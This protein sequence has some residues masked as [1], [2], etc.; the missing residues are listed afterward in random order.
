MPHTEEQVQELVREMYS[1]AESN[2]WD[3]DAVEIRSQRKGRS[4]PLP[5]VKVLV[6]V[7]AAVILIVVGI[8]VANGSPSHRSTASGPTTTASATLV[9]VPNATN[10][11]LSKATSILHLAGLTAT[12]TNIVNNTVAG[13]VLSQNPAAGL[14]VRRGSAVALIVSRGPS[15]VRVPSLVGL[16]QSQATNVLGQAG[17]NVGNISSAP[18]SNFAA[19]FVIE[20]SPAAGASAPPGSSV[21]VVVSSGPRG[22]SG[23]TNPG[24]V[25]VPSLIGLSQTAAG[26]TLGQA[27]LNIGIVSSA[28]SAQIAPGLVISESPASGSSVVPGSSVDI[29]VSTGR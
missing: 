27:G 28:T 8:V 2:D 22:I 4:V 11:T 23:T 9:T 20:S 26:D 19:N 25:V 6:L 5:D 14:Q 7:A 10:Q 16:S 18:S 13:S 24:S 15:N 21:A 1:T 12:V 29:V 3:V 17:L